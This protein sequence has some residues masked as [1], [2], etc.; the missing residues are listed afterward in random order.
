MGKQARALLVQLDAACEAVADLAQ[1]TEEAF[2]AH[3]DAPTML[4]FP[5]IGAQIGARILA[6]IGD[7]RTRFATTGGLRAYAGAAPITRASGKRHY[8][9][10][11]FVKKNRLNHVGHLWAFS[12]LSGSVGADAHCRRGRTGGDWHM[13]A[14]RHL[15]NRML[16]QL[17]HCLQARASFDESTA[18]P[19]TQGKEVTSS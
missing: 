9:G 11:R 15:F 10:R 13:Q 5:G 6:E 7:D 12:S 3:P 19:V 1:V 16:G 14:L 8:V 4:R 18:F 2:Q 17:H